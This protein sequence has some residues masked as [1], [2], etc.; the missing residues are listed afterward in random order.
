MDEKQKPTTQSTQLCGLLNQPIVILTVE[1][2]NRLKQLEKICKELKN[3]HEL[4]ADVKG[5]L[6]NTIDMI[7]K[8]M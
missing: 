6:Q 5:N 7:D 2:Y 1:E 3:N 4:L 8:T